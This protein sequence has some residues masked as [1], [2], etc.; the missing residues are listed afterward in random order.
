MERTALEIAITHLGR[1]EA[2]LHYAR[3][4]VLPGDIR[5]VHADVIAALELC[6]AL[7]AGEAFS[8]V[9]VADLRRVA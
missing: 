9:P 5:D 6:Q 3:N 7:M 1:A 8:N 2:R 4:S